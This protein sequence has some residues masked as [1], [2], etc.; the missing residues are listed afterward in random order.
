M[1]ECEQQ[2]EKSENIASEPEIEYASAPASQIPFHPAYN[3]DVDLE[4]DL[5]DEELE[6]KLE[7]FFK[8]QRE[9]K[10]DTPLPEGYHTIEEAY[11]ESIIHLENL[12]AE[13]K[14]NH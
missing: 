3:P 12:Y 8:E 9:L 11:R 2:E 1:K 7:A 5:T 13:K 14:R 10:G 4:T 6:S